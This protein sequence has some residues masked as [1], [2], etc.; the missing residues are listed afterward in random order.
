[1]LEKP[2][3]LPALKPRS[4]RVRRAVL[5]W[6]ATLSL[7]AFLLGFSVRPRQPSASTLPRL[8]I[9]Q[10]DAPDMFAAEDSPEAY[11]M[12]VLDPPSEVWHVPARELEANLKNR[13]AQNGFPNIGVSASHNG[14]VY[15]AGTLFDES[16]KGEIV[17]L[18]RRTQG[19]SSVH[20]SDAEVRKLYGPAYFGAEYAP[21]LN[22]V[23]VTKVYLGSPAQMARIRVGDVITG[24]GGQ[25]VSDPE[26]LRFMIISHVGGQRIGV[27]LLRNG[28][29]QTV[30]VRLGELPAM[31]AS[32]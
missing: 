11:F 25:I 7:M 18:V 12:I 6:S 24:F 1:M 5:Y 28:F 3:K 29:P 15:L 17:G 26:S 2:I 9:V 22:G 13:L 14:S 30:T 10:A 27:S 23:K 19:V 21:S 32:R 20:F 31:V 4:V 16:E 8:E